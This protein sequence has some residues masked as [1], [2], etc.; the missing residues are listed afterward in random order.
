[1]KLY[2]Y[3]VWAECTKGKYLIKFKTKL[4]IILGHLSGPPV[5]G[6]LKL[7]KLKN[8]MQVYI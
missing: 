6:Y 3:R 4:K 7:Y 8:L 1:M 5:G 2:M